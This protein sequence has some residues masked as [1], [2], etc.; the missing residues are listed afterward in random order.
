MLEI[1]QLSEFE[2]QGP[3][4]EVVPEPRRAQGL[5]GLLPL[6]RRQALQ[7][8]GRGDPAAVHAV[9]RHPAGR[10][11]DGT[12]KTVA[13]TIAPGL[14]PPDS[15]NAPNWMHD[16]RSKIDNTCAM[17]HGPDQVG[18]GRRQLLL[19]PGLPRPQVAGDE[20][21]REAQLALAPEPA[22]RCRRAGTQRRRPDGRRRSSSF[23][24][25]WAA[26]SD[27]RR[28][29]RELALQR[30]PVQRQRARGGRDVA[31]VLRAARD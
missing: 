3:H 27:A 10:R 21:R 23:R 29:L 28:V 18:H 17:C 20:P 24:R 14:T 30:A 15:H 5:P 8:E 9:P 2:A 11:V 4:V 31:L 22:A 25:R 19:Q 1:L 26:R 13:S 12:L 16:H 7:R 6:P